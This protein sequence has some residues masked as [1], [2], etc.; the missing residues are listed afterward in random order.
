MSLKNKILILAVILIILALSPAVFINIKENRESFYKTTMSKSENYFND[1][2]YAFNSMLAS[3]GVSSAALSDIAGMSYNL[4]S[5]GIVNNTRESLRN[6]I[7]NFHKSQT[8]LNYVIANGIY[9]E[10]NITNNLRGLSSLYLYDLNN[11]ELMG[12]RLNENDYIN[13]E[14]YKIALPEDWNR[15]R[16]RPRNVYYSIPYSK[17]TYRQQKVISVSSPVY[18]SVS[19][20]LIGVS[21][22]D[23]SLE[24]IRQIISDS[25]E[26]DDKFNAVIFDRGNGKIIYHKNLDYILRDLSEIPIAKYIADNITFYTNSRI[27]ENY[28]VNNNNYSLFI[29][30]LDNENYNLLMFVPQSYFYDSLN[31]TNKMLIVIL[32]ISIIFVIIILNIAIPISLNPLKKISSELEEGVFNHDIFMSV[33]KINSKDVLGD[34]SNWIN[35]YQYMVQY[36]FST[37]NKTIKLSK[38]QSGAFINKVGDISKM[39][40]SMIE[41][42][43]SI[44]EYIEKQENGI[45]DIENINLEIQ[46]NISSNLSDLTSIGDITKELQNKIDNQLENFNKINSIS[47]NIQL[48]IDKISAS[49]SKTKEESENMIN[50]VKSGK[51]RI[52]K[53][54]NSIKNLT[55]L[56]RGITDFVN[57]TI[58]T[59][60]QTNMLAMNAA[61]EAAHAGEQ[62]KGFSIISEEIRK[63]AVITNIQSENA[64]SIIRDMEKQFNIIVS[65]IDERISLVDDI[66]LQSQNFEENMERLKKIAEEKSISTKEITSSIANLHDTVKDVR[67]Q[68]TILHN[69]ISTDLN[70]LIR[71]SELH[72]KSDEAVRL[73]VGNANEIVE[74][75]KNIDENISNLFNLV[76]DIEDIYKTGDESADDLQK[77]IS[78]YETANEVDFD[79]LIKN[80]MKTGD[81]PY[82]KFKFIKD[83]HSFMLESVGKDNY[84][85]LLDRISD[86]SKLIYN[87]IKKAKYIK[88]FALSSA[89]F[90]PMKVINEGFYKGTK[91]AIIDKAK[92]DFNKFSSFKKFYLRLIGGKSLAKVIV[93]FSN[94][95]F[96]NINI[97][98]VK[99][100]RKK[101]VYHLSY[102]PNYDFILEDYY[103]EMIGNIFRQKY[104]NSSEV[105]ITESISKGY[106]YT[107]Y[108]VT[109]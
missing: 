25:I 34:V 33:S 83:M 81:N 86:D 85:A 1:I 54:E 67:D 12:G 17:E 51:D 108:I 49:M 64:A 2:I 106:I 92:Y 90:I 35:I 48:D 57:S 43:K 8:Y 97:E 68:Y 103:Y 9:F 94:K 75:T 22:S 61:I 72:A 11:T 52:L 69:K 102:F 91:S 78:N 109:W 82:A 47:S 101:A 65:G 107:E 58:D 87:D 19:G 28:K 93:N 4:Y 73:A 45:K 95:M 89:F 29:R 42:S 21:V 71:L 27:I 105:K 98:V 104:P 38:E 30:Q 88:R 24:N 39:S 77:A 41:S 76:K 7:Y 23:I 96:K 46:Q 10:P 31:N 80:K 66:V 62:G 50:L 20:N 15:A 84:K 79:E 32:I 56:M 53:T 3:V 14:F 99:L 40:D 59:S 63:L 60:Q 26:S 74:K 6:T 100:D 37:G 70:D 36:L 55:T 13:E 5:T 18:S 44:V 16:R